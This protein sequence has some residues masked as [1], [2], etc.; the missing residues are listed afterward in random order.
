MEQP[1]KVITGWAGEMARPDAARIAEAIA[2][3][4]RRR[5]EA[6]VIIERGD[7]HYLQTLRT[8]RGFVVEK[9]EGSAARH[10]R[11]INRNLLPDEAGR[12]DLWAKLLEVGEKRGS[13]FL[14]EEVIPVFL[15]YFA[16]ANDPPAVGWESMV[17]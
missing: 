17:V 1:A 5:T 16:G 15:A 2:E 6:Y 12:S 10:L 8:I 3:A 7:Q 11:A 4:N 14:A 9:R 13:M